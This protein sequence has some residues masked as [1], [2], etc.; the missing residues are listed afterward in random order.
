MKRT[1]FLYCL[2]FL[3]LL[4]FVAGICL[5][6]FAADSPTVLDEYDYDKVQELVVAETSA[7][8]PQISTNACSEETTTLPPF[9]FQRVNLSYNY[10]ELKS[11]N[12]DFA[13]WL[14]IPDTK[15]SFPVVLGSDNYYYLN[16][17]FTGASSAFGCLY[18]DVNT[19]GT[20]E[21]RVIHGHNMGNGREEML[22]SLVNYQEQTFA[23][24]HRFIY[25]S[26][27]E[28]QTDV[29]EVF[30]VVN[31]NIH[32]NLGTW[33]Y[34]SL[35]FSTADERSEYVSFLQGLSVYETDFYPSG[36]ILILSTCNRAYGTSNRLLICASK[37]FC[38][39][40]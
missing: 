11:V 33:N 38:F 14:H 15:I 28:G 7:T 5:F 25:V 19:A 30:A 34:M 17:S 4:V 32:T 23:E 20:P 29:Y 39:S 12:S 16:R 27:T 1:K 21:H 18:F 22:S 31:F 37:I 13:A 40:E 3:F 24:S 26:E 9:E 8:V 35:P 36:N 10:N 2:L 6:L